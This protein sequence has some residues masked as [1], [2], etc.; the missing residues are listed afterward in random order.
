V[1]RPRLCTAGATIDWEVFLRN[2][3]NATISFQY[4]ADSN[5]PM[6]HY[7]EDMGTGL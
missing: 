3:T 5:Y 6:Y 2:G 7:V 4:K 1:S